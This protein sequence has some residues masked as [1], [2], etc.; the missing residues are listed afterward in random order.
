MESSFPQKSP[1]P[2]RRCAAAL[3]QRLLA[4]GGREILISV[5]LRGRVRLN[6]LRRFLRRGQLMQRLR[7]GVRRRPGPAIATLLGRAFL[8]PTGR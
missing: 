1:K 2:T 6:F 3:A 5:G 4:I 8:P 7:A